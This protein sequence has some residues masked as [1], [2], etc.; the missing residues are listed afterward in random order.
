MEVNLKKT[1]FFVINGN[2]EDWQ[3]V[4][5]AAGGGGSEV[6]ASRTPRRHTR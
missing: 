5:A 4:D 6:V 2:D 1:K 3:P